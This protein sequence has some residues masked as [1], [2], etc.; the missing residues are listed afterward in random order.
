M[1]GLNPI[2]SGA[3]VWMFCPLGLTMQARYGRRYPASET[4]AE[5]IAAHEALALH[6]QGVEEIPGMASNGVAV[7]SDMMRHVTEAADYV[8][9]LG[10]KALVEQPLALKLQTL[11][12]AGKEDVVVLDADNKTT[13]VVEFKY[14]HRHVSTSDPRLR[15]YGIAARHTFPR[16][17]VV[18]HVI[19]P[20]DYTAPT[21]R[22]EEFTPAAQNDFADEMV[23][24]LRLA[25]MPSPYAAAGSHCLDCPGRGNCAEVRN[26]DMSDTVRGTDLALPADAVAVELRLAQRAADLA[27]ARLKGL[28]DEAA[29][30]IRSG[31]RV[32]GWSLQSSPGR[33][34]VANAQGFKSLAQSFGVKVTREELIT[35]NQAVKAGLPAELVKLYT[36]R[37]AGE[38][39]L[40]PSS[41]T[42]AAKAFSEN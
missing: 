13:H 2:P 37:S 23:S 26:W 3:N 14:G 34:R 12:V 17:R 22:S 9:A 20:R 4:A 19:Q 10:G 21:F 27:T 32:P 7:D 16:D 33:E 1:D 35:P 6:L 38:P 39:K 29:H 18:L 31:G 15:V 36:T 5:G 42:L 24:A 25:H 8:R 28:Q 40:V 41:T 11:T 30:V